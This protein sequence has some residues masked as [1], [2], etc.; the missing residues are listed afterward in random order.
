MDGKLII[1]SAPSGAG[2]TTIVKYLLAQGLPIAFS[3]S[4]TNRLPRDKEKEGVDYYFL[5]TNDF[6]DRVENGD[7]L[8]WEE[9]Y[10]GRYYG[11]LKSEVERIWA[12]GKH[13]V[14]DIDVLGGLNIKR[15]FGN[16]ALAIFIT[17]PNV[18]CLRSRL[19]T[20]GT[21]DEASLNERIAKAEFEL[22]FEN[23]FDVAVVNDCLEEAREKVVDIVKDFIK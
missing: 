15:Q 18:E 22:S 20:R 21:E 4:A 2:K 1:L 5:S 19:Q 23:Q 11:T 14:F 3:I 12:T 6:R 17:P 10:P 7:F 9:V 13:V 16:Q 8:E